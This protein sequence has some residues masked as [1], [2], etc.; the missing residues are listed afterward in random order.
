MKKHWNKINT[1][2]NKSWSTLAQ[3]E[4][5]K[6][7]MKIINYF[8]LKKQPKTILDIGVGT[9]R[10]LENIV[11]NTNNI[12]QVFAIDYAKNMV[13]HCSEKFIKNKK[14]KKILVCDIS[15][16][17]IPF[18]TK[19]DFITAIRILQY[20]KNWPEILK[21]IYN[22]LNNEGILIFTLPN[23]NSINRFI[24]KSVLLN[25]A[26]VS[27]LCKLLRQIGFKI[28]EVKCVSKIPD[29]FYQNRLANN[30]IYTKLLIFAE[31]VL[32][33]IF[34]KVFMGRVIFL[35]VKKVI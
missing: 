18:N 32:E 3:K 2:Y 29:F 13:S 10:I 33:I 27:K 21:K 12:T 20:N 17:R 25:D 35:S 16:E 23:Y 19:F 26:T 11:S 7:E 34:G 15:C 8:L 24:K 31:N 22:N 1:K 28:L 5:S 30:F 14:V 6:R 4:M 9:G